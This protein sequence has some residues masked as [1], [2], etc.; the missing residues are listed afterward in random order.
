MSVN[1]KCTGSRCTIS[2]AS[3]PSLANSVRYRARLELSGR[4]TSEITAQVGQFA[5]N[6]N[7]ANDSTDRNE[8]Q[9]LLDQC[10]G[11][12]KTAIMA[13]LKQVPPAQARQLLANAQGHLRGALGVDAP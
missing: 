12:V 2:K 11:E 4:D 13:H 8:A 1:S 5:A 7:P 10:G 9:A 6:L 3:S